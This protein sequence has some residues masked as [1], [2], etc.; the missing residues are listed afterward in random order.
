MSGMTRSTAP[1]GPGLLRSAVPTA[2]GEA[3]F[4]FG[5]GLDAQDSSG[6]CA[7]GH[8]AHAGPAAAA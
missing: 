1:G 5:R 7:R 6:A 4:A 2:P 3:V 8:R